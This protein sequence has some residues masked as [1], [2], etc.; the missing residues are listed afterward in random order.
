MTLYEEDPW[1]SRLVK[2]EQSLNMKRKFKMYTGDTQS[3][4]A[5]TVNAIPHSNFEML[6]HL[7]RLDWEAD[8]LK[9]FQPESA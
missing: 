3:L 5:L 1:L 8:T 4:D 2:Y 9:E 7:N 6:S